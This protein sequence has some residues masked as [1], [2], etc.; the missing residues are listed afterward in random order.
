MYVQNVDEEAARRSMHRPFIGAKMLMEDET[1]PLL[2]ARSVL[3][4]RVECLFGST[5]ST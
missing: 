1:A 4:R 3:E 5:Q 2:D